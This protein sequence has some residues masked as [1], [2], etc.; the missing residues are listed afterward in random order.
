MECDQSKID[1]AITRITK[2]NAKSN[3]EYRDKLKYICTFMDSTNISN[4]KLPEHDGVLNNTCEEEKILKSKRNEYV[5]TRTKSAS[6]ELVE[7]QN[8]LDALQEDKGGTPVTV[9]TIE[10]ADTDNHI[11]NEFISSVSSPKV[12]SKSSA[13][14]PKVPVAQNKS[15]DLSTVLPDEPYCFIGL[16]TCGDLSISVIQHFFSLPLARQLIYIPCCYHKLKTL[17]LA[18]L[19]TESSETPFENE[20][21][22]ARETPFPIETK[23]AAETTFA[24]FPLSQALRK[25][26]QGKNFLG[27]PFL[28][29][30]AQ[31][32]A[33]TWRHCSE[34]EKRE[35]VFQ[36]LFRGVLQL[37]AFRGNYTIH[38]NI[39]EVLNHF[40]DMIIVHV[41]VKLLDNFQNVM[42]HVQ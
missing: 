39:K 11:T 21:A 1:G 22:L 23:F 27:I 31:E 19:E 15:I 25:A 29:L 12:E 2:Q 8:Y 24:N 30:A 10:C 14:I 7:T 36:L 41:N 26:Y 5:K 28:R 16:H 20:R 37:Y 35:K 33:L 4:H 18:T 38:N 9:S 40:F 32:T 13:N 6:D 17:D 34:E 3:V 42:L